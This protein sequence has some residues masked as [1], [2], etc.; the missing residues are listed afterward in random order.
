MY[1]LLTG[2]EHALSKITR[3]TLKVIHTRSQQPLHDNQQQEK[4]QEQKE[5]HE[6]GTVSRGVFGPLAHFVL[7]LQQLDL[8]GCCWDAALPAFG[9]ACTE[10]VCL[11][12]Q[13]PFVPLAALHEF[14]THLPELRT[15]VISSRS[16]QSVI[17]AQLS[18]YVDALL[19]ELQQCMHLDFLIID[20]PTDADFTLVC[21][22]ERWGMLPESLRFLAFGCF[23]ETSG[24]YE[25][26]IRTVPFLAVQDSPYV[27]QANEHSDDGDSDGEAADDD[28]DD[29]SGVFKQFPFLEYLKITSSDFI[30]WIRYPDAPCWVDN[31][32]DRLLEQEFI[33]DCFD[34]GVGGTSGEMFDMLS[35][36]PPF[37]STM[38]VTLEFHGGPQLSFLDRVPHVFPDVVSVILTGTLASSGS[39]AMNM[40]FFRPLTELPLLTNLHLLCPQ[41]TLMTLGLAQLCSSLP[42]LQLLEYKSCTSVDLIELKLLL[43]GFQLNIEVSEC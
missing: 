20:F 24:P 23:V 42:A 21:T 33:L 31:F 16:Y 11:T 9:S 17:H 27:Q 8:C 35:W 41:L 3:L 13:A 2:L 26:L 29:L 19:R 39:P 4:M 36:L 18:A 22:P 14:G 28:G 6:V 15:V 25:L 32:K 40:E 38:G 7:N 1:Q 34:M 10:L 37:P 43:T 30:M 5:Q 12:L